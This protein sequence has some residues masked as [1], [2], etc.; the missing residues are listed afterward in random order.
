MRGNATILRTAHSSE[1][2]PT[3]V[4][5]KRDSN[6]LQDKRDGWV[7]RV[8]IILGCSWHCRCQAV[9]HCKFSLLQQLHCAELFVWALAKWP[10]KQPLR[11][12]QESSHS[13]LGSL[14]HTLTARPAESLHNLLKP[15]LP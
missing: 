5:L 7:W 1:A 13:C 6:I 4:A 3:L 2:P 8:P 11:V 14:V 15:L 12:C 9:L 10:M